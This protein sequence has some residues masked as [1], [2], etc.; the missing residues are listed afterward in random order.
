MKLKKFYLSLENFSTNDLYLNL[1]N[2]KL[3]YIYL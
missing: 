1:Y 3:Y 2:K